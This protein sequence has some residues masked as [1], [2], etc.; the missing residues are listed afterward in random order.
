MLL[1]KAMVGVWVFVHR[2]GQYVDLRQSLLERLQGRQ[3]LDAGRAPGS[4]EIQQD[5]LP[6][7][8]SQMDGPGPV[9]YGEVGGDFSRLLRMV[10]AVTTGD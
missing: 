8:V 2:H 4:P 1:K 7:V 10:S 9:V 5:N 3:F 6:A